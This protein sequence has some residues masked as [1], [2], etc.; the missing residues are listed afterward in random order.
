MTVKETMLK[1]LKTLRLSTISCMNFKD[2]HLE[3]LDK[4]ESSSSPK[5][6]L[7]PPIVTLLNSLAKRTSKSV[8]NNTE[9]H[10]K[11]KNNSDHLS[12]VNV[13]GS[14]ISI[15]TC[16]RFMSVRSVWSRYATLVLIRSSRL[17]SLCWRVKCLKGLRYFRLSLNSHKSTRP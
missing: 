5:P 6:K 2:R 11:Y 3:F 8:S 13:L 1:R 12:A 7:S 15:P 4:S 16:S 14:I 10:K 9:K 17:L